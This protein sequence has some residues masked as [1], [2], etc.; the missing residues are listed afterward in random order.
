MSTMLEI[1]PISRTKKGL[2]NHLNNLLDQC[3]WSILSPSE[4]SD[5]SSIMD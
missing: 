4:I 2:I 5:Q 3:D 1:G